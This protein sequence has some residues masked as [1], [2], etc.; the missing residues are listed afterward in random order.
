ML[1][2][3][4]NEPRRS[5][6]RGSAPAR[7][8]VSLVRVATI[9][10]AIVVLLIAS[11]YVFHRFEQ[12]VIKDPRFALAGVEG[13]GDGIQIIGAAHASKSQIEKVF[14]IDLARS[15]Y[16]MPLAERRDALRSV[17]WVKDAS[18]ARM[19][20]NRVMVSVKERKP[21]AFLTLG[22]SRFGL[23][24]EDGVILPQTA[25]RF[26]L[27]V[28]TGIRASDSL[29]T[30]RDRVHL[31]LRL[32]TGLG[33]DAR[34]VSEIDVSDRDNLKITVP[35]DGHIITLLMGDTDFGERYRKFSNYYSAI[36][37]QSP[38]AMTFDLRLV[39]DRITGVE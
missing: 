29:A 36:R 16:L 39:P 14:A 9:S 4:E 15:V 19:W 35:R 7:Q 2:E 23:I 20:P 1:P 8:G 12:F 3:T 26:E 18:I 38:R 22:A 6:P 37:K 13:D 10:F 5:R 32:M 27:P 17:D 24:D 25:G 21:V 33:D 34:D 31:M 28:L 30:R 11:L